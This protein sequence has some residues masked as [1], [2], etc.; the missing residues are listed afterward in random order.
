MPGILWLASYPKSGNT[1]MRAFLANY[2]IGGAAPVKIN[3]LPQFAL[4]DSRADCFERFTDK[5]VSKLTFAEIIALRPQVQEWFAGSQP[6][7]VFVK[8]HSMIGLVSGIPLISPQATVGA[9]YILRNP[10]DVALSYAHHFKVDIDRTIELMGQKN[11]RLPRS[12]NVTPQVIGSWSQHVKTW[13]NAAGMIMKVVRY[14]DMKESPRETFSSVIEFLDL[15]VVPEK[16]DQAIAFTSFKEM[17][18]QEEEERFVEGHPDGR[19]FFR[20]GRAGAWRG[21]LSQE[22]VARILDAHGNVMREFGYLDETGK[23]T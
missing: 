11:C 15:D 5:S 6:G 22:Q 18:R 17:R 13:M 8:T 16:L 4:G 14:E 1:W 21:V 10:L 3:D 23:P 2:I 7:Q 12:E 9:I 19:A 20:E